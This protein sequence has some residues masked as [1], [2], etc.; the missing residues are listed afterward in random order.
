[1]SPHP[2]L[3]ALVFVGMMLP[4]LAHAQSE[5]VPVLN[6]IPATPVPSLQTTAQWEPLA[7]HVVQSLLFQ[8]PRTAQSTRVY[9]TP[10][11][12]RASSFEWALHSF[13]V[14]R[15]VHSGAAVLTQPQQAQIQL[16][17]Q[18]RLIQPAA[19]VSSSTSEVL[20]SS[21]LSRGDRLLASYSRLYALATPEAAWFQQAPAV[22]MYPLQTLKVVGP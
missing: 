1:M 18:T 8:A 14:S 21:R 16:S 10:P 12:T 17:L 11:S 3:A 19:G 2:P 6:T 13:I 15:L 4:F 20:L 22:A 5:S 7:Q 9:V